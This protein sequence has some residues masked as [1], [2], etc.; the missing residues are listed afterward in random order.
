MHLDRRRHDGRIII[1]EAFC[2]IQNRF[3]T[4]KSRKYIEKIY[5]KTSLRTYFKKSLGPIAVV[6][7]PHSKEIS[8][9][10]LHLY[11]EKVKKDGTKVYKVLGIPVWKNRH[12]F[13]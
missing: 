8:L 10:G 3:N 12:P 9:F 2:F 11:R 1:E 7:I 6:W 4:K 13:A 5:A